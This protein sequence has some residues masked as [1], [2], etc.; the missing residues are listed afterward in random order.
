[1]KAV[2]YYLVFSVLLTV[3]LSLTVLAT[4]LYH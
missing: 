4:N 3:V 2:S 1:M